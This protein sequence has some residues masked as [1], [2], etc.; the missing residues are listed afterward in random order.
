LA[1]LFASGCQPGLTPFYSY[2]TSFER[3]LFHAYA[4]WMFLLVQALHLRTPSPYM[5]LL[6]PKLPALMQLRK[7]CQLRRLL[8]ARRETLHR[9]LAAHAAIAPAAPIAAPLP[10]F[11]YAAHSRA[12][13]V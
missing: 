2:V 10:A 9:D 5:R 8:R 11:V 1:S 6:P 13:A 3:I 12:A 4:K 7:L